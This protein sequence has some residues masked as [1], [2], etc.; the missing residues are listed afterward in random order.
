MLKQQ[1]EPHRYRAEK[2]QL[3]ALRQRLRRENNLGE[4]QQ[5][6]LA[7]IEIAF[8]RLEDGTFGRCRNCG[9]KLPQNVLR[10]APYATTCVPN[11]QA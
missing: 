4:A 9:S 1:N 2:E 10:T 6:L 3:I 5:C 8:Q 7:K 11:C